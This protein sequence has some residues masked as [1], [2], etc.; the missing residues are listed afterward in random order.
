MSKSLSSPWILQYLL[1]IA[2]THGGD[3]PS[4]PL[5][6]SNRKVQLIKFLTHQTRGESG[7]IWARI[8]D[9]LY[10]IPVRFSKTSMEVYKRDPQF[11]ETLIHEWKTAFITIKNFHPRCARIALGPTNQGMSSSEH[12]FLDV[13]EFEVKAALGE[14]T[15]GKPVD[16]ELHKDIKLWVEGLREGG[17]QGNVLKMQKLEQDAA[18]NAIAQNS[19]PVNVQST[20]RHSLG[21]VQSKRTRDRLQTQAQVEFIR[22]EDGHVERRERH[23]N[24]RLLHIKCTRAQLLPCLSISE[25]A[26]PSLLTEAPVKPTV[27]GTPE[28][29]KRRSALNLSSPADDTSD[30]EHPTTPTDWSPSQHDA[31]ESTPPSPVDSLSGR[32]SHAADDDGD[33]DEPPKYGVPTSSPARASPMQVDDAGL[34]SQPAIEETHS[35]ETEADSQNTRHGTGLVSNITLSLPAPTPAQRPKLIPQSSDNGTIS[36]RSTMISQNALNSS[37]LPPMNP[38]RR[39][40]QGAEEMCVLTGPERVLVSSSSAAFH[41]LGQLPSSNSPSVLTGPGRILVANSDTSGTASHSQPSQ[42]LLPQLQEGLRKPRSQIQSQPPPD[43]TSLSLPRPTPSLA[44]PDSQPQEAPL[45]QSLEYTSQSQLK[46]DDAAKLRGTSNGPESLVAEVKVPCSPHLGSVS[47]PVEAEGAENTVGDAHDAPA[48]E[49]GHLSERF[50]EEDEMDVDDTLVSLDEAYVREVN[51]TGSSNDGGDAVEEHLLDDQS[52]DEVD[53]LVSSDGGPVDDVIVAG[54]YA[55]ASPPAVDVG[56]KSHGPSTLK[57]KPRPAAGIRSKHGRYPSRRS[58]PGCSSPIS[59]TPSLPS[60]PDVF[61]DEESLSA[62]VQSAVQDS[63]PSQHKA[64][65]KPQADVVTGASSSSLKPRRSSGIQAN[66]EAGPSTVTTSGSSKAVSKRQL[67]PSGK[68][69]FHD[70][71]AWA[72]PSFLQ[73]RSKAKGPEPKPTATALPTRAED[74]ELKRKRLADEE[75][76]VARVEQRPSK[77]A[78]M[79]HAETPPPQRSPSNRKQVPARPTTGR[80][81]PTKLPELAKSHSLTSTV[82]RIRHIDLTRESSEAS[83]IS[84]SKSRRRRRNKT[85]AEE[86]FIRTYSE[87][88]RKADEQSESQI[89]GSSNTSSRPVVPEERNEPPVVRRLK[90]GGYK[91]NLDFGTADGPGPVTWQV[92]RETLQAVQR[93]RESEGA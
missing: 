65:V 13:H 85:K 88:G 33:I 80:D 91:L 42:P 15:W 30:P 74:R 17:G 83:S 20:I 1:D 56:V 40:V 67:K 12:V 87:P 41:G 93:R 49:K 82:S 81:H 31:R 58:P 62:H 23:R 90:L 46:L 7:W 60:E 76:H 34:S 4:V 29:P 52:E 9:S 57:E 86:A 50:F 84:F 35:C 69:L 63:V 73:S 92:L 77:K 44:E 47:V 32:N 28:R 16:V 38:A 18:Q 2:V 5:Y 68:F 24:I 66:A 59:R 79:N 55:T 14:Q 64:P 6:P 22:G 53:E 75:A 25:L 11:G 37:P 71:V 72:A 39:I 36:L 43:V 51:E 27:P 10:S 19:R 26:D 8:S 45:A 48:E 78:K 70:P 3:L 61:M 54:K 21:P 89:A